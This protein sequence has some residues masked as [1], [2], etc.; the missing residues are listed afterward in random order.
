MRT[1]L[2]GT[3]ALLAGVL[4]AAGQD[5]D[6][7]RQVHPI[8][9]ARCLGCHSQEKR[10]GGLALATLRDVLEGGR[11]GAVVNP[12]ASTASLIVERITGRT[13]PR[14]PLG[15]APLGAREIAV[16]RAWIDQGARA[17][18]GSPPARARWKA[19][20]LLT[21]PAVP[22]PAWKDWT[23]PL[24]RIAAAYLKPSMQ[25]EPALVSDTVF[26]RRVY[27]DMWGLLPPPEELQAFVRDRDPHKREAL[28]RKLLANNRQYAENWISFWNDLLRND[29]GANYHS[30]MAGRK[31]ITPWLLASLESNRPYDEFVKKLLNPVAAED[32]DGFLIGVNWRGT[33]SASQ[34]PAMQ[35]AQ[36][37]AQIFLGV[38]LK[39]NS[40][41]DSFISRWKLKDAYAMASFFSADPKLQLYRC[42][43][44]QQR[45]SEPAFLFPELNRAAPTETMVDRRATAASIFTD[46]KNGRLPRTMVNR[47]WQRMF[48][49]GLV[50]NPDEMDGE[51]WS[52]ALLDWLASDFV[53]HGYDLKHLLETIAVSRTY[54]L[55]AVARKGEQGRGFVFQGPE[56][57]RLTAEEFADA[58]GSITG[59]WQ[60]W[61]P[62]NPGPD[63]APPPRVYVRDWR[64]AAS[65][66]TSAL[67]R[68]IR[69][70][71]YSVRDTQ[72]TTLQGLEL[73]N[74]GVLTHWLERGARNMLGELP[75]A[76]VS[77]FAKPVNRGNVRI[78]FDIDVSPAKKIWL[79]VE[80]TGSYS[81]EKL[82]AIW[83]NAELTG[84]NGATALASL[85]PMDEAGLRGNSSGVQVKTP[86]VLVYDV[87]G[88]GFTRLRG[89]V[90]IENRNV[91]DDLNPR[92]RFLIFEQEPNMEQLS[93][94]APERPLPPGPVLSK[95]GEIVNRVFRYALG[96]APSKE[97]RRDAEKALEDPAHPA[98]RARTV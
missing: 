46:A 67:G 54:Q 70:Q 43:V 79:V 77:V 94:V 59:D 17:T 18:P 78:P 34:T 22:E 65:A 83:E 28:V 51:P 1:V 41:H 38:N 15:G 98:S 72:A 57:R 5:I 48:G 84:P 66:L 33:I 74:G 75:A 91:T 56:V 50:E 6:F 87:T 32:P 71:V 26:A 53:E 12:G 73:E 62:P 97:E 64:V 69:D 68:P 63:D 44:A 89:T 20:L 8:L 82:E 9:A 95:S 4:S 47:V 86:S 58:I 27:L 13:E 60:T 49:R 11:N 76:P 3:L 45:F 30:E 14:M 61:Q 88:K 2:K 37:T 80:D 29:D 85:Q 52:P 23:Q 7:E 21:T 19:P 25:A 90:G 24:D 31:S 35:A 16:I 93:P 39:C 81:P 36:N 40:C 55:P 42:D 10:S 92:T 96:R